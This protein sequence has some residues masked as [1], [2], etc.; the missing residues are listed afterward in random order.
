MLGLF[1]IDFTLHRLQ[2]LCWI[3]GGVYGT[4]VVCAHGWRMVLYQ[5][6]PQQNPL[7]SSARQ[8]VRDGDYPLRDSRLLWT[9]Q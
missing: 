1:F 6:A 4:C 7:W 5:E 2:P 3:R 8:W 9:V